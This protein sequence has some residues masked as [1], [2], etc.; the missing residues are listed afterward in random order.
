[1]F[2]SKLKKMPHKIMP[3]VLPLASVLVIS[4]L[5]MFAKP[6]ITGFF[7]AQQNPILN[8]EIKITADDILPEDAL[9]SIY[10]LDENNKSTEIEKSDIKN[11]VDN[12]RIG[13]DYKIGK[14][15]QLNYEGYGYVGRSS[16]NITKTLSSDVRKGRYK[17]KTEIIYNNTVISSG[18]QNIEI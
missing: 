2:I 18:E 11:F 17:L 16:T 13:L 12:Y 1:M 15:L 9:I 3:Y 6:T 7:I 4:A 10:L 5:F 8:A 14:N